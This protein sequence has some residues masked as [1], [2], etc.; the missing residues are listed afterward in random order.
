MLTL[1]HHA[2][3]PTSRA[4]RLALAEYKLEHELVE[5]VPWARDE[6][7]LRLNPAGTVPVL[8]DQGVVVS[9]WL[10]G[11]EYLDEVHG[12][13]AGDLRYMPADPVAR[14]ETRR[15]ME[16]F[17]PKFHDEVAAYI[18]GEKVY[19]RFAPELM[20]G[21]SPDMRQVHV[22]RDNLRTHLRY[23]G[24]LMQ[25]RSWLAGNRLSAADLI[26]AAQISAI[27]YFG[28]VPWEVSERA[29]LWYARIK[30]RPSFRP[31]LADR[32]PGVPPAGHYAD[33]D[34]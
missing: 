26:A 13:V 10:A 16:W 18:L 4:V 25:E 11:L 27:D 8:I 23:I 6:A 7:F 31:L 29:K 14:A 33:L 9:G 15:L 28:D 2:F 17:G 20:G 34:F 32:L 3:V 22:A 12:D 19:R 24:F 30:S 1:Y 5:Q 21:A